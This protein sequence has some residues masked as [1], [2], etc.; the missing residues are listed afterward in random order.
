VRGINAPARVLDLPEL[1]VAIFAFLLNFVWEM[2]QVPFWRQMPTSPHFEAVKA[3]T[4]ATLGD[5]LIALVSFWGVAAWVHSRAWILD[6]DAGEIGAFVLAG[7]A[8]TI[9]G[10][11]VL[12]EVLHRWT[13]AASMP[14]LPVL[15]TGLLP[16]LQ[17]VVLPPMIVWFVHRQL[18]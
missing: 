10:E 11:W 5:V 4:V 15:G 7:V 9:V 12:T 17:W 16:V 8:I 1:H 3:C 13:Y 14:T 18:T 2:W 6:P